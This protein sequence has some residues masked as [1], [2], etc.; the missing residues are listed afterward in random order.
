[1]MDKTKLACFFF[2]CML[3]ACLTHRVLIADTKNIYMWIMHV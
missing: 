2:A 3:T 1:M